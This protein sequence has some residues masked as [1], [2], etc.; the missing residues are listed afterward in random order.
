ML[1][2]V[3]SFRQQKSTCK[4]WNWMK[5]TLLNILPLIYRQFHQSSRSC[6]EILS[7]TTHSLLQLPIST[8][9][10]L[11]TTVSLFQGLCFPKYFHLQ[12]VNFVNFLR[13][14]GHF[15]FSIFNTA[16]AQQKANDERKKKAKGK[17]KEEEEGRG[18]REGEKKKQLLI[19]IHTHLHSI[20]IF[21]ISK[22]KS[23]GEVN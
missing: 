12:V 10:H 5:Y 2:I 21:T 22:V 13:M 11:K 9:L 7:N 15:V 1:T 4:L 8:M 18:G 20:P 16:F 6:G 23:L 17:G 19:Q 14:D 3:S